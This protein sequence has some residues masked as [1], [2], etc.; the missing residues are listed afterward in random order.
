MKGQ[1]MARGVLTDKQAEFARLVTTGMTATDAYMTAFPDTTSRRAAS[2]N[3]ARLMK[4]PL[5]GGERARKSAIARAAVDAAI[6]RYQITAE[7]VA[8]AMARLAFTDLRQIATVETVTDHATGKRKQVVAIKDFSDID[9]DAHA[10]ISEVRRS[11]SGEVVV[12]LYNKSDALMNL[13][14]IKGWIADKPQD[15]RQLV[16]LKVER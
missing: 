1:A 7:R 12:K 10:A 6:V 3:G 14:R 11:A 2:V 9:A 13:A 15:N 5:I 4:H 16:L 8:D